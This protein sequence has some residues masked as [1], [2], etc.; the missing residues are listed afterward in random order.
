MY[1]YSLK[2]F[3]DIF[4]KAVKS[5]EAAGY[6]KNQKKEKRIY[7]VNQFT[8]SLYENVSR[9]LFQRHVLLFSFLLCL[10]IMDENL[11]ADGGLDMAELRFFLAGA[12]QVELTKPNPTGEGGWLT[13][14]SWLAILEMSSTFAVFKG[15][16]DALAK[17]TK[18]WEK[19]YASANP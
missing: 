8:K 2:Y 18:A 17:D 15:L 3:K 1:Q 11:L 10:K 19:I 12:T 6:E 4:E 16:D 5:A 7:W 13:D 14:K 9:S